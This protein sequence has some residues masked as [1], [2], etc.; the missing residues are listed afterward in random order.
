[1]IEDNQWS[2]LHTHAYILFT[3]KLYS[4]RKLSNLLFKYFE[5]SVDNASS[6][7]S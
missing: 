3:W 5:Y 7:F 2:K 4:K 6:A 1:M